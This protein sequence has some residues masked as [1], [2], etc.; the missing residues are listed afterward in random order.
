MSFQ[1]AQTYLLPQSHTLWEWD[2]KERSVHWLT[3]TTIAFPQ[4]LASVLARFAVRGMPRFDCVLLVLAALRDSWSP[5]NKNLEYDK[6]QLDCYKSATLSAVESLQLIHQ[7]DRL[8]ALPRE[9][10]LSLPVKTIVC[11][12]VFELAASRC[13]GVAMELVWNKQQIHRFPI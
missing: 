8:N 3:G 1:A 7:L 2:L 6:L 10:R 4:E 9:L 13:D 12:M 5:F 11:D